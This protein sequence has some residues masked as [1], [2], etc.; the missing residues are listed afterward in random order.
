[1]ATRFQFFDLNTP[2][3]L[4]RKLE[5]DLAAL[6]SSY[7]DTRV[8]FNFFVTA[9]HLP[10][11]LGKR[12]L[13]LQHAILRIVSHIANGAKHFNLD[14]ARHDSVT[15]TEKSRYVEEG[16][17][18]PGYYHEPLLIH[19]SPD[20]ALEMNTPTIDAVTLGRQVIEFWRQH[21][22]KDVSPTH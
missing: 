2:A 16:Y 12:D 14:D 11:W 10:N 20:E 5:G 17:I 19:L 3:D 6:E 21:I 15:S 1:M 7:Q 18:E 13:I 4:F 22:P 8:A 9:E